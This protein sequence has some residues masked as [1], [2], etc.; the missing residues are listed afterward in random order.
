MLAIDYRGY[1]Y[2]TGHPNETGLIT[3]GIAIVR[4]ALEE[5]RIPSSRIVLLGQSLGTAIVA[6]VAE[7]FA[8][9]EKVDFAGVVLVAGFSD[10]GRML[11]GYAISGWIPL[12]MPL[13]PFPPLLR[14]IQ[15]RLIVDRWPSDKRLKN[16]IHAI[17]T[18][19]LGR[20]RLRLTFVHAKNDWDI[21]CHED[22]KLFAA[23]AGATAEAE[24]LDEDAFRAAKK[25][26]T[27][28]KGRNAFATTWRSEPDIV[29]RQELFAHGGELTTEMK[30]RRAASNIF[31]AGHNDIMYYAP[32][33]LAVMRAFESEGTAS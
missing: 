6:A 28:E 19:T 1:G 4:F 21:P 9:H 25:S 30:F 5:L 20:R 23:A 15:N 14:L 29:I 31:S 3:D 2:S 13:R 18:G 17:R 22:D 26:R 32:V 7:S 12:L 8:V 16:I 11:G 10:L 24:G 33:L 27:V